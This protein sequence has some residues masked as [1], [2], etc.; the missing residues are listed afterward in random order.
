MS[1]RSPIVFAALS[2]SPAGLARHLLAT[3]LDFLLVMCL[4]HDGP[5]DFF[6]FIFIQRKRIDKNGKGSINRQ[7]FSDKTRLFELVLPS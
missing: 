2:I 7:S 3:V 4:C 1:I 6:D 5:D